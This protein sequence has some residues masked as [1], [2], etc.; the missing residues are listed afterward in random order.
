MYSNVETA[1]VIGFILIIVI[2]LYG[3]KRYPGGMPMG[4]TCSAVISAACHPPCEDKDAFKFPVQ[5][6]AVSHSSFRARISI[7]N[8]DTDNGDN[9]ENSH[10]NHNDNEAPEMENNES[11]IIE[12]EGTVRVDSGLEASSI[13]SRRLDEISHMDPGHCCFTTA[14]DVEPPMTGS[15]YA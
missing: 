8:R 9:S 1:I 3:R 5:W 13:R 14:R 15:L 7:E 2:I 4:A 6:G 12:I 10:T 11:T